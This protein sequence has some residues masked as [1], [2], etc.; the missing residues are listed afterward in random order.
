MSEH[1]PLPWRVEEDVRSE[2]PW[3]GAQHEEDYT[4]GWN[5]A[6]EGSEV[7]GCEGILPD[8]EA[9]ARLIVKAVNS[10]ALLLDA[11]QTADRLL[12]SMAGEGWPEWDEA[13][14]I[15]E[16]LAKASA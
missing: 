6:A 3:T 13:K 10:H 11:L 7:V 4:S 15:R 2:K 5:I 12:A 16:A 1:S 9:N 14:S 8:G